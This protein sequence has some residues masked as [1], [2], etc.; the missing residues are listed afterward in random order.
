MGILA[1][2]KVEVGYCEDCDL[3]EPLYL[4]T[5][6]R[7]T[8]IALVC[9]RCRSLNVSRGEARESEASEL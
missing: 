8:A 7:G 3:L 5:I 2:P 4:F 6:G 1:R 9:P